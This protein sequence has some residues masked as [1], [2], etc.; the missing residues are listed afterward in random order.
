MRRNGVCLR[1]LTA[2]LGMAEFVGAIKLPAIT[3]AVMVL[4]AR[5]VSV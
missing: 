2:V 4:R 5:C 3:S 1:V